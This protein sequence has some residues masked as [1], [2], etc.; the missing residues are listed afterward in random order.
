MPVAPNNIAQ[1]SF[2]VYVWVWLP[3]LITRFRNRV[4]TLRSQLLLADTMQKDIIQFLMI[5]T[6][7]VCVKFLRDKGP[8]VLRR[9]VKTPKRWAAIVTLA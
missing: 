6:N 3:S 8:P 2:D 5:A 1:V 7:H 4:L 9:V